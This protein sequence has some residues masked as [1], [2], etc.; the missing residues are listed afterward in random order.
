MPKK[1]II[2]GAGITGL[3]AGWI[4]SE[5]G[6]QVQVIEKSDILGGMSATFKHND[7]FLDYGPHK[8]FTVM[9]HIM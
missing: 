2:L 9:P 6:Y 7:Y 3:S 4:L 1:A 8:I 5:N